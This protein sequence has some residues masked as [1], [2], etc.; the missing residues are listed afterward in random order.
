MHQYIHTHT[1]IC[2]GH[3]VK[4]LGVA[5]EKCLLLPIFPFPFFFW[6]SLFSSKISFFHFGDKPQGAQNIPQKARAL[7]RAPP[8]GPDIL[9]RMSN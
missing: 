1:S 8:V 5:F 7:A 6:A 9:Y 3:A 4:W 2:N